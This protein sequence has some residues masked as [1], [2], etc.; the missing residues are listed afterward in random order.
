MVW[1]SITSVSAMA[2]PRID[3]VRKVIERGMCHP[4]EARDVCDTCMAKVAALAGLDAV[5][6]DLETRTSRASLRCR[7]EGMR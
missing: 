4:G 6:R 3:A 7:H 2:D 5:E 1:R